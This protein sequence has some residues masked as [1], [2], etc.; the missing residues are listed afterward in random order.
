LGKGDGNSRFAQP[1]SAGPETFVSYPFDASEEFEEDD[2]PQKKTRIRASPRTA[3]RIKHQNSIR[4]VEAFVLKVFLQTMRNARRMVGAVRFE[5]TTSC[6]RNKR[7]SQTTLRPDSVGHIKPKISRRINDV[8]S[9]AHFRGVIKMGWRL[10][11]PCQAFQE[12]R[13]NKSC[14]L[15][16]TPITAGNP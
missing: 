2:M 9:G 10:R 7:A 3:P 14:F 16:P 11:H 13:Q 12:S 5:L 6:T 15:P 8:F 4:F 1:I